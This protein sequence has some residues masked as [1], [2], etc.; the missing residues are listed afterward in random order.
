VSIVLVQGIVGFN[1]VGSVYVGSITGNYGSQPLQNTIADNQGPNWSDAVASFLYVQISTI[2]NDA[3]HD[4]FFLLDNFYDALNWDLFPV[5]SY[6][7]DFIGLN[8]ESFASLASGIPVTP[9]DSLVI[10]DGFKSLLTLSSTFS[11]SI[12]LSDAIGLNQ[13]LTNT[14]GDST[15]VIALSDAVATQ[16]NA[17]IVTVLADALALEDFVASN[18][19]ESFNTYIRRYLNDVQGN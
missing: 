6:F 11:D 8:Q 1:E 13:S 12:S 7:T 15:D 19:T 4:Q 9:V 2:I 14:F 10:S 17:N 3:L 5:A 16:L 18:I